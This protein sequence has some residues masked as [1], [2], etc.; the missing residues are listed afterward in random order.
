[1]THPF[2]RFSEQE[3]RRLFWFFL[4]LTVLATVILQIIDGPLKTALSPQ[5]IVSF[6]LAGTPAQ[7]ARILGGWDATARMYAGF[8]LGFDYLYMLSY[9]ITVA[10]AALWVTDVLSGGWRRAGVWAAWGMGVAGLADASENYFLWRLL[11]GNGPDSFPALARWAAI[12]KFSLLG[13]GVL[14][15]IAAVLRRLTSRKGL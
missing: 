4:A 10:L 1:M 14:L 13:L 9:T 8:S 6:E 3:R 7:S 5:G 11:I 15:A 12:L 2:L